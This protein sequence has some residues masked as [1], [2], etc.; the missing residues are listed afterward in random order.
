[1]RTDDGHL[2]EEICMQA[3][4]ISKIYPG[5]TALN[6]VD[7]NVYRGKVNV[8]IGE[9]GAGKSTLMKIMAGI[10]R[11]SEGEICLNGQPI[12]L[13]GTREA[14]SKGIGIIHQELNLFP[15]LTVAQNIFMAREETKFGA[16]L[17][18]RK[19]IE[20]TKRILEKLEHP[21]D[22][23][24]PVSNLKVGQQQIVEIAKTMA[25]QD[26]HVLIMDEPTSSLSNAEV[27]VLFR[28]IKE[29]KNKG[30]S[31]IYI[32]HRLD[33][34]MR[35]GDYIT[36]LRDGRLVAEDAVANIDV[37][38]IVRSMVGHDQTKTVAKR[39]K[40]F[41]EEVLRVE[42][43]MLQRPGTGYYL[44]DVS[45]SLHKGE[46][47]GIYG[48][49]G[50]GRTELI[51]TLMG[52][53]AE[54]KGSIYME[55]K[56]IKPASVW[57]Q[58]QRGFAHIP[59]DRQREGLIQTLSIAKNMTLSSW[60]NY[61]KGF[62]ISDK[63]A[64]KGITR[65]IKDLF[66]KA[67]DPK[68][69]I[70]SLSGGNQQ[71]VVIGKGILTSPKIMLMDEPSR[72]IDVGAKADVYKIIDQFASQGL[73]IILVASELK[74]IIAISDRVL[75]MSGGKVTGEFVGADITEQNLVKA[76]AGGRES[77]RSNPQ[78]ESMNH[79]GAS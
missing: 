7:F 50:A 71:K 36:I 13:S 74:E 34:I 73:S 37:P 10:E 1:M 59:E 31:I 5:T 78:K 14:A 53:H 69:P 48:L 42:S 40:Q 63:E 66:I 33:E 46:I 28:L 64:N 29:L 32:S 65:M 27:E 11:P 24:T 22:P 25:Q 12:R 56:Q 4:Q 20:K 61:T 70:L 67:A 57:K 44:D 8:L 17:D 77:Y 49:L 52:L 15:N 76:S 43:L 47:L 18:Q 16:I 62:H 55:G 26:L 54:A 6:K 39:E 51:E 79:D 21:I 38:W 60:K 3:R 72:G 75:V 68:L 35:I 2:S 9:N 45:F 30:I 41:S 58:I 23:H 19:H